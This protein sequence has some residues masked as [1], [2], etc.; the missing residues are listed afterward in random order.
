MHNG[1]WTFQS[2]NS[3]L[4]QNDNW[5]RIGLNILESFTWVL[6]WQYHQASNSRAIESVV[7]HQKKEWN[8]ASNYEYVVLN[9]LPATCAENVHE[10]VQIINI[11]GEI[12]GW[13]NAAGRK[14]STTVRMWRR[15]SLTTCTKFLI[16]SFNAL[17]IF[18]WNIIK[19]YRYTKFGLR[20]RYFMSTSKQHS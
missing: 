8:K 3:T 6:S 20:L 7:L 15:R 13:T 5:L 10:N 18:V 11:S 1:T 2:L 14:L 9:L 12:Q 19:A 17:K 4:G 16:N